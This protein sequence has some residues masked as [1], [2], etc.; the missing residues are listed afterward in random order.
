M[1]QSS[2]T[3]PILA[4]AGRYPNHRRFPGYPT[5]Q[6]LGAHAEHHHLLH[7]PRGQQPLLRHLGRRDLPPRSA[8]RKSIHR[9]GEEPDQ[10]EPRGIQAVDGQ[11]EQAGERGL[12][13]AHHG[14]PESQAEKHREGRQGV[15]V[16]YLGAGIE[17]DYREIREYFSLKAGC[18][19]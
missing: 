9:R 6:V 16:G 14:V 15:S 3:R 8:R 19:S 4:K 1:E 7:L 5:G 13:Q 12:L 2:P 11:Q 17:E 10:A 18:L